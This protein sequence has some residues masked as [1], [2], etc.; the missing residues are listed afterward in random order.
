MTHIQQHASGFAVE[1]D[2]QPA[3]TAR[4]IVLAT[5]LV[6]V[7]PEIEHFA[8]FVGTS[9]FHCPLCD[10]A[11]FTDRPIVVV[12]WGPRAVGYTLEISHWTQQL[13]LVTHG[14]PLDEAEQARLAR[15]GVSVRTERVQRLEGQDSR[16]NRV[17]LVG[18]VTVRCDAVFFNIAHKP[19]NALA[20]ALGCALEPEG[21]V[22]VDEHYQT[23]VPHVYAAGDIT[24][25]EESVADAVAEGFLAAT[26][27]H[28]SLYLEL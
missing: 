23:T 11:A 13:T 9:V 26:H 14:H 22:K 21:Y 3:V 27:L 8:P 7:Q 20:R 12:S 19:R 15:Y 2:G 6:D 16:V 1:L 4:R 18:G 28:Q 10:A 17:V 5:S 24:A 25:R